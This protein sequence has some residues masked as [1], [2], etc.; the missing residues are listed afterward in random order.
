MN[1]FANEGYSWSHVFLLL[2]LSPS[3]M[4]PGEACK[5]CCPLV[6]TENEE[7]R[8]EKKEKLFNWSPPFSSL[9]LRLS[10]FLCL[11]L[12]PPLSLSACALLLG[13]PQGCIWRRPSV[14]PFVFYFASCATASLLSMIRPG[15]S[16]AH[17]LCY[18]QQTLRVR[19][20]CCWGWGRRLCPDLHKRI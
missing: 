17:P 20:V 2:S 5:S 18:C 12:S 9:C 1:H 7:E 13:H 15:L 16:P 14:D 11:Y 8:E 3:P 4:H 19:R 10:L 6:M